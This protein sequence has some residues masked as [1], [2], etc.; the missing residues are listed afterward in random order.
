MLHARSSSSNSLYCTFRSPVHT[1]KRYMPAQNGKDSHFELFIINKQL[2][3]PADFYDHIQK[4]SIQEPQ[5]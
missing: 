1:E 4:A 5:P 2:M 3:T